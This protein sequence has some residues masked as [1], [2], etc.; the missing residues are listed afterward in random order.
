MVTPI[1][2]KIPCPNCGIRTFLLQDEYGAGCHEQPGQGNGYEYLPAEIH[3]LVHPEPGYAPPDPLEGEHD[4]RR[5]EAEPD[6][7]EGPEVQELQRRLP[8]PEKERRRDR[9]HK[10]HR[11]ELGRLDEGPRHTGVLDHVPPD[12]LALALGQ[13]ERHPFDLG[14]PR[15]IEDKEHR[16]LWPDVPVPKAPAL[17][18]HHVYEGEAP[19]E[20]DDPEEAQDQGNLIGDHLRRPTQSAKE[21]E[22]GPAPVAGHDDAKG[23]Y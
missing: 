19:R 2:F 9:G 15:D 23:A 13:V 1:P 17:R 7:V 5:L 12:D 8:A 22:I 21:S 16:K 10:A 6:P 18:V 11:G 4:E 20:H 14:E 3:E